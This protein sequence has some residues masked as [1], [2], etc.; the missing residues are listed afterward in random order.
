MIRLALALCLAPLPA[1]AVGETD[2]YDAPPA[3]TETTIRCEAPQVWDMGSK[4]CVDPKDA[5]LDD[6]RRYQAARE[7]AWAGQPE[8]A[9][10]VLAAM[11]EGETDRVL[12]YMAFASRKAGRLGEGLVLYA[13]ALALNPDNHL[14]RSYLGMAYAEIGALPQAEAQLAEIR[15][16]GGAGGWPEVALA[17]VIVGDRDI[18]Y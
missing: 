15:A 13:R 14:A 2:D 11:A 9:L 7:Y 1:F 8:A 12:T 18:G 5:R 16:R 10:D 17:R 3:P 4:A 6:D